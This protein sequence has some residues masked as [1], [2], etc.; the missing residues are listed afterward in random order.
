MDY[1]DAPVE[2]NSIVR[3]PLF[4]SKFTNEISR[5]DKKRGASREMWNSLV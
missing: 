2:P 5:L 4:Q 1:E 3:N